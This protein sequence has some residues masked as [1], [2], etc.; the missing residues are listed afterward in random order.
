VFAP[1]TISPYLGA[2]SPERE[3]ESVNLVMTSWQAGFKV[4]RRLETIWRVVLGAD[5]EMSRS[6][7]II[8]L[9]SEVGNTY[10][11]AWELVPTIAEIR[12]L[13]EVTNAPEKWI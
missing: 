3:G 13:A 6:P 11:P 9:P 5:T 2:A 10:Q 4:A 8:P 1:S 12:L 7:T